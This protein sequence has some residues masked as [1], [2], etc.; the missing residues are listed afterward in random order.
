M[1]DVVSAAGETKRGGFFSLGEAALWAALAIYLALVIG[2]AW[3][4]TPLA[5]VLAAIGILAACVHATLFYGWKDAL[6]L[7]TICVFI[8]FTMENIGVTTGWPF[9]HYHFEVEP[10][11]PHVGAIPPPLSVRSG[12][13]WDI[14]RGF[15]PKPCS[16]A[17]R[18]G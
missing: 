1:S 18:R 16:A 13:A 8:T 3:N 4:R 6:A 5:E 15:W 12:S 11:L 14:S 10:N 2:F 17:R 9:G 7:A